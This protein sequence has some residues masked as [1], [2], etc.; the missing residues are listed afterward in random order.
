ME[1]GNSGITFRPQELAPPF[2]SFPRQI[3]AAK[4]QQVE[5]VEV[6]IGPAPRWFCRTLNDRPPI[7][8]VR[9][10]LAHRSRYRREALPQPAQSM[11]TVK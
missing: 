10:D 9:N 5:G 7:L 11:Q 3:P 1:S 4:R 2:E 8:A 6:E